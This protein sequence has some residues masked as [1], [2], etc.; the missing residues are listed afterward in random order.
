M[1]QIVNVFIQVGY[2]VKDF[3]NQSSWLWSK[4]SQKVAINR[5]ATESSSAELMRTPVGHQLRVSYV[6]H[7]HCWYILHT[8]LVAVLLRINSTP[9][10]RPLSH[11]EDPFCTSIKTSEIMEL[12]WAVGPQSF[13][14]NFSLTLIKDLAPLFGPSMICPSSRTRKMIFKLPSRPTTPLRT[15]PCTLKV[16]WRNML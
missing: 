7:M 1:T 9:R 10:D 2:T 11:N 12:P 4:I 13:D 5:P 14:S 16:L 6:Q 8:K 15:L 3:A